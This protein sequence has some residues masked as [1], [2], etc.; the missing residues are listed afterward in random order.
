MPAGEVNVGP[1][2]GNLPDFARSSRGPVTSGGKAPDG[3]EL[4]SDTFWGFAQDGIEVTVF[5]ARGAQVQARAGAGAITANELYHIYNCD[6]TQWSQ[7][8]SLA[9]APGSANDA[10]IVAWGMNPSSGTYATFNSYLISNGGA[11]AGF[12]ADTGP[13]VKKYNASVYP[14]ENDIKQLVNSPNVA[15]L[16]TAATSV[17]NPKNWI[18]WGSFGAF[19][20]YPATSKTVR[21]STTVTAIAAPVAGILPSTSGILAGT[22]PIGRTLY[23]VT[24]KN[25]A[26]CVKTAGACDFA[27]HP[28]PAIAGPPATTDLN[29]TGATTG[30]AGAVREYTRFLCRVST[31]QQGVSPFTGVNLFSEITGALNKNG[32]TT[33]PV[34]L[35]TIWK[36]LPGPQLRLRTA[37]VVGG[38]VALR[39]C[40]LD[41]STTRGAFA[42]PTTSK[43]RKKGRSVRKLARVAVLV[44]TLVALT[45]TAAPAFAAVTQP[46][47]PHTVLADAAG[48]P[49]AFT[50][51]ASGFQP[52]DVV[53]I[54][55]CDGSST[56]DVFW[57]PTINC[58]LGSSPAPAVADASGVVTFAVGDSNHRFR[59]FAGDSPQGLFNC[60]AP[61]T[62]AP[63]SGT[64]SFTNCQVR[65]STSN[66][67]STGDQQF[68]P[69]TLPA[70]AKLSCVF[71][72][73]MTF[74]KPL[75]NVAPKK[76][77]A[78]KVKGTATLGTDA[79]TACDNTNA[80]ASATKL[81]VTLGSGEDQGRDARGHQVLG[82]LR[83]AD[84][85]DA[86]SR[87]SG[88]A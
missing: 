5:N 14:L 85:R 2:T 54:E 20:A 30:P 70:A 48:N 49:R 56:S 45:A 21:S 87:S 62:A 51:T 32:F 10:P 81:P 50:V 71:K 39:R 27:G 3:N 66:S 24:R 86:R 40:P 82:A 79:G 67:S 23:H 8:P 13:C 74:N 38:S 28:G 33:V 47:S 57:D 25:D 17:D 11:P 73:S 9:I 55:Q 72:G 22:Y 58:D 59:P 36:S 75:T 84:G 4:H 44:G 64:P 6:F 88:R 46:T 61:G 31:A 26:D 68:L 43:D 69:I 83:S 34:A 60:R 53:F 41:A 42:T 52:D 19:S 29:V 1:A 15:A 18:W 16:S 37:R 65:V 12:L 7:I 78:T 63:T 77:K 80:P 76:P 35:R